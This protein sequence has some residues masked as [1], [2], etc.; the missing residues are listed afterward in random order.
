MT[1]TIS[2]SETTADLGMLPVF[3]TTPLLITGAVPAAPAMSQWVL[4]LW[5][6][7]ND[8]REPGATPL[9]SSAG[10][11]AGGAVTF[12]LTAA[13]MNL[14]L[15]DE[16]NSNNYWLAIGGLDAN[17]FPYSLRAGN[18]EI[19]PSGLSLVPTTTV[20]FAVVNE[21][22]SFTFNGVVYSFDVVPTGGAPAT[23]DGEAVVIDGMIVVTVDGV[24]YSVPA[25][26]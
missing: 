18:I 26:S 4:E 12:V 7:Q 14:V 16:V 17:G 23:I 19:K 15:S 9:A 3:S 10:Y 5:K 1:R 21:V 13:Q 8:A 20:S 11:V 22:A 2:L 25:V 24:S 6:R